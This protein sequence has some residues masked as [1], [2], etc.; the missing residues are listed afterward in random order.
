MSR[1]PNGHAYSNGERGPSN[2]NRYEPPFRDGD[3]PGSRREY[4]AGGYGGFQS[5]DGS[6]LIAQDDV[7]GPSAS[8]DEHPASSN[9]GQMYPRHRNGERSQARWQNGSSYRGPGGVNNSAALYG[10]GPGGRQ[11]EDVLLHINDKWDVMA[12]DDCLPVHVALQLM[13]HSSLGRGSDYQDFQRT[14]RHLQKAL[15][16]IV[17]EHHQGFN[18]SIGTFHKIQSSIQTSQIRVR[19]LKDSV[20][21]AKSSLMEAKPELQTLGASSQKYENMLHVLGQI[22]KVQGIPEKLDASIADKEFLT[23]VDYLQD[24]LRIIRKSEVENVG[25]LADLK[26]YFSNQETSLTDVLVEELHDHLYLK[27]PECRDRWKLHSSLHQDTH[28][29]KKALLPG[30]PLFRFLES[31]AES[32]VMDGDTSSSIQKDS[33][34]YIQLLVE[35]LNKLGYLD[36]T[37]DRIDQR[38]PVELYTVVER[39]NQ[40]IRLRHSTG[41]RDTRPVENEQLIHSLNGVEDRIEVLDDLLWTLY[42]KF[43]AIAESHRVLHDVVLIIAKRKGSRQVG[44]LTG[45]FKELWKLFQS[46]LRSLLHDYIASDENTATRLGRSAQGDL[47][48]LERSRRDR[49]KRIFRLADI[50]QKSSVFDME[51]DDLDKM[52][53][54]SVPGLASKSHRRSE[55]SYTTDS[56]S[57]ARAATHELL[58]ESSIFNIA[59]LLPPSLSFLQSLKDVVPPDSDIA[60]STLTSFLD[61]FL[62]N[63]FLPQLEETVSELCTQTYVDLNAY[64][65][66]PHWQQKSAWPILKSTSD[67]YNVV[68][69][70]C[71]LLDSLPEDQDFTQP[72]ISQLVSYYDRCNQSYR[73]M[74]QRTAAHSQIEQKLKPAAAMAETGPLRDILESQLSNTDSDKGALIQQ[75]WLAGCLSQ[76]RRVAPRSRDSKRASSRPKQVRRWTLLDLPKSARNNEPIYLP[77]DQE[78]TSTFDGILSS[79]RSLALSALFT[80]QVDIRCGMAH[81]AGQL[82]RASYLLPYP[83]NNPDPSALSLNSDLLSFDDTLST[84]LASKEHS[85]ITAGL[86][87][88]LDSL[89]VTN[90]TQIKSMDANGCGRMQLNILV[91]QQNLKAVE[92]DVSLSHSAHFFEM[93]MEGADAIMAKMQDTKGKQRDFSLQEYRALL[94]LCHSQAL[95]SPQREASMHARK[96]LEDHLHQLEDLM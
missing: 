70:L 52:L 23:A 90:A 79:M 62:I 49:L 53:Q 73:S 40:E 31:L 46:E 42:S 86:A 7:R 1:L 96:K 51:R 44:Q 65:K 15:R 81:M 30:R 95:Q 33:F 29:Q 63:V 94:E 47:N 66:D 84:Y 80:L 4:R 88:L 39:T 11:I 58:A 16:A 45:N 59:I 25:A 82:I 78:S 32:P 57:K 92:G 75:Q 19:S 8:L 18:S 28:G 34:R 13:D 64:Q 69:T 14:S 37:V 91:L 71:K 17:N 56:A 26:I 50:D 22:E 12:T 43:E 10:S 83:I 6:H 85:F 36:L 55:T 67:F 87:M 2:Q 20:H 9:D 68:Q 54:N 77:L 76:L 74:V 72:I 21:N 48:T 89:L 41:R 93:F 3:S 60:V 5:N 24:A 38:L 35:A 61:D 27:S